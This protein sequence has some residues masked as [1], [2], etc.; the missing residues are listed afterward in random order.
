LELRSDPAC[1]SR[2]RVPSALPQL[3]PTDS[4]ISFRFASADAEMFSLLSEKLPISFWVGFVDRVWSDGEDFTK[5][6]MNSGK[7]RILVSK[8]PGVDVWR[9]NAFVSLLSFYLSFCVDGSVTSF[10]WRFFC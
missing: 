9:S 2:Q 6:L 4:G 5:T 1:S 8:C 10:G 3:S 7:L